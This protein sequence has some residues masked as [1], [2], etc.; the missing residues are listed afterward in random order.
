[1]AHQEEPNERQGQLQTRKNHR[2]HQIQ[3]DVLSFCG[4][5]CVFLIFRISSVNPSLSSLSKESEQK[6]KLYKFLSFPEN[7]RWRYL[8]GYVRKPT[9]LLNSIESATTKYFPSNVFWPGGRWA[10]RRWA[11]WSKLHCRGETH[12]SKFIRS[13]LCCGCI[14]FRAD[15]LLWLVPFSLTAWALETNSHPGFECILDYPHP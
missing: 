11:S 4:C 3:T 7:F 14:A 1:M 2:Q 13:S 5:K 15:P 6:T 10:I 12:A 8:R 9:I